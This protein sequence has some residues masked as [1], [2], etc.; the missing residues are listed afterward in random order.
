MCNPSINV[1]MPVKYSNS[2]IICHKKRNKKKIK[3]KSTKKVKINEKH[4][5][6]QVLIKMAEKVNSVLASSHDSTK[7]ANKV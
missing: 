6:Q 2:F 3:M 5:A 4:K 1:T 7:I